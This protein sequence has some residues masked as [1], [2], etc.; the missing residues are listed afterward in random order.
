M[1]WSYCEWGWG[2]EVG[3]WVSACAL[4]EPASRWVG[5]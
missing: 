3:A 1:G 5:E 2:V 4:V